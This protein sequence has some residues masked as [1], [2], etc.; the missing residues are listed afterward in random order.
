MEQTFILSLHTKPRGEKERVHDVYEHPLPE[1]QVQDHYIAQCVRSRASS[2]NKFLFL[3]RHFLAL[4]EMAVA[5][6]ADFAEAKR[7]VRYSFRQQQ[8][9]RLSATTDPASN[10]QALNLPTFGLLLPVRTTTTQ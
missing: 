2:T 8:Q 10:D 3:C 6:S 5:R 9:V 7:L 4:G 1:R